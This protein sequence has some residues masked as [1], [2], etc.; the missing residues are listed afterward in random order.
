MMNDIELLYAV[1]LTLIPGLSRT[2]L[3]EMFKQAGSAVEAY[4]RFKCVQEDDEFTARLAEQVQLM[5]DYLDRARKELEF[6]ESKGIRILTLND[7]DY[8]VR[9][10]EC[11]DAPAVLYYKGNAD[12]NAKHVISMVGTRHC[13]EYG[14]DMCRTFLRDLAALCPDVLVI[15]GLAYGIDVH[16]HQEALNNRLP[17]IGV[18]AHGLDI[19]YPASHKRIANEMV[20]Q[21]GL[22]TEFISGSNSDKF[23]FVQRNRI[24]AGMSD[25]TIVVES[26]E[27]GGSLITAE[28]AEMYYRDVFACPGRVTDMA[29]KGCNNLIQSNRASLLLDARH[30]VEAMGWE[31]PAATEAIQR[32]LFVDLTS[33]EE[34]VVEALSDYE[35]HTLNTLV[36]QC[37]I[38]IQQMLEI[39]F[40][41]EMK[42]VVKSMVGSQYRLLS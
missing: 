8:P 18:L 30:F 13:T 19:L 29:S 40:G 32:E 41:L 24:V 20:E 12:L 31:S 22:L 1:A 7:M 38:P 23:H 10:R 15:S 42:G 39:L 4:N 33:V 26:K 9:L 27:Q 21:G 6:A 28:L 2:T 3:C 37:D 17:T 35:P 11:P 5:P 16:A 36:V 34:R 25:A 14:R